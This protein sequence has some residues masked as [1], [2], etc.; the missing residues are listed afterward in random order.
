MNNL[1]HFLLLR[2]ITIYSKVW[3]RTLV[4]LNEITEV[5]KILYV[6]GQLVPRVQNN[7][8]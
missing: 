1:P 6:F 7:T 8:Q 2:R 5:F 4:S 3:Y